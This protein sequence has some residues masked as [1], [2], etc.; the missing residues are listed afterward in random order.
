MSFETPIV[1]YDCRWLS[2]GWPGWLY[3]LWKGDCLRRFQ[4][5]VDSSII[6]RASGSGGLADLLWPAV[7][8]EADRALSGPR[9]RERGKR[10]RHFL[11]GE[12]SLADDTERQVTSLNIPHFRVDLGSSALIDTISLRYVRPYRPYSCCPYSLQSWEL[13]KCRSV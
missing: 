2:C 7:V 5:I 9:E 11:N 1:N 3:N 8:H 4:K 10:S 6:S 12:V 13:R